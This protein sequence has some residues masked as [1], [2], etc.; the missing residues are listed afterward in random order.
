M[1][2][3]NKIL[4]P[5]IL[6]GDLGAYSMARAFGEATG[7]ASYI[8]ARERLALCD[9]SAFTIP[10]V[11]K[12]LDDPNVAVEALI[13]FARLHENEML[14]LVPTADWYMEMLEYSRDVLEEYYCFFIPEFEL[15]RALTDKVSFYQLLREADITYPK[16]AVI[17]E[18]DIDT[19]YELTKGIKPPYVLKPSDSSLYWKTPFSGMQ[20][21]YF[22]Y[23][24]DEARYYCKMI[25]NSGYTGKLVIQERLFEINTEG[26][27]REPSASVLT[28]FSN[29][30]GKVIRAVMGD[31]ALEEIGPTSRGNYSAIIT[32]GLDAFSLKLISLL[33]KLKYKGIA[34]FDIL[35]SAGKSY[36]LELNAR[37]GRSSDYVRSSG[38]N[39]AGLLVKEMSGIVTERC[40]EYKKTLWCAVPLK[41]IFR[42]IRDAKMLPTVKAMAAEGNYSMPFDSRMDCGL[43]RR[44]YVA[45][46]LRRQARLYSKVRGDGFRCS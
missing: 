32:R 34:N 45:I 11:V 22:P 29:S 46:H 38:V 36:C 4:T 10:L 7:F 12:G 26:E 17:G 6:G 41:C 44:L 37:A 16:T 21:V 33:D 35:R 30:E 5:V 23:S 42:Q 43:L 14:I 28:T 18:N 15:W 27:L 40:Y 8:F 31:I 9:Y 3:N 13:E 19:L 20:K 1:I 25:F 2:S 39:L 24:L